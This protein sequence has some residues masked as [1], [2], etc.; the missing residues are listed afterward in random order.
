MSTYSPM[1]RQYNS[2]KRKYPGTI[3]FFR[4]GDFYEMFDEDAKLVSGL[5]GLTLTARDAGGGERAPMCGVPYHSAT[6]YIQKLTALGYKIAICEQISDPETSR[7]LV[8]RDVVRIVTPGTAFVSDETESRQNRYILSLV[9]NKKVVGAAYADVGTGE[10]CAF[11]TADVAGL[12]DALALVNPVEIIADAETKAMLSRYAQMDGICV[13]DYDY[14]A[15]G[16][17][18]AGKSLAN[19]FSRETLE[20][21]GVLEMPAASRA[22]AG[23]LSY[24][25]ETQRVGMAHITDIRVVNCQNEMAINKLSRR[26]LELTQSLSGE[27]GKSLLSVIDK[28][29]TSSGARLLRRWVERPLLD[30]RKITERHDA[31]EYLYNEPDTLK[32]IRSVLKGAADLERLLCKL[33]YRTLNPRDCLALSRTLERTAKL[34]TITIPITT[35]GRDMPPMLTALFKQADPLEDLT[36]LI[37]RMIS[38]NASADIRDGGVIQEGYSE[39]LDSLRAASGEG[40]MWMEKL[41][42]RERVSTGI[43]SLKVIYNR[44]FGYLIEV[45]KTHADKVPDRYMRRQT[46][47]AGERYTTEELMDIERRITGSKDKANKLEEQLFATLRDYIT[48]YIK[49]IIGTAFAIETLD[50]LASLASAAIE[51]Q[52]VRPSINS[53]GV[54]CIKDGRHPVVERVPEDEGFIP[55]D[56]TLSANER[57]QIITGPNMAGKSTYMRQV[58]LIVLLNQIGSFVPASSASLCLVD[59]LFTRVGASDDLASGQSTFLVEMKEMA[60]ILDAATPR[61]L[62]LLDEIGRGTATFDGLSIAWAIVEYISNKEKLGALTMF[63]THYHELAELEGKL[64][65]V[66]NY[67]ARVKVQGEEILFL[68]KIE[69]GNAQSSYGVHAARLAGLPK[70]VVARANSILAKIEAQ[71]H[72][73]HSISRNILGMDKVTKHEQLQLGDSERTEFIEYARRINVLALNPIEAQTELMRLHERALRL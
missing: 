71:T 49:R 44:V 18:L 15:P 41:E 29:V 33:S 62:I 72:G 28:T 50:A 17:A 59:K 10:F 55:N 27:R 38:P 68:R 8:D 48:N 26:N 34:Q 56:T 12:P 73:R 58:A 45:T 30:A 69:R 24:I 46:L 2:M 54:I 60:A 20:V 35:A 37:N 64:D 39:E 70:Q 52:Y 9:I 63:A 4:L 16:S 40:L 14:A 13:T 66:V 67:Y 47:T 32:E 53:D 25:M 31:V 6:G 65:G 3:V 51:N 23:L 22:V 43:R 36:A 1:M 19:T 57:F 5:L 7:G 61:S 42:N 11:E 21:S